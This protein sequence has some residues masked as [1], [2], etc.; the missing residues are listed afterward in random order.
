LSTLTGV[1]PSQVLCGYAAFA[2]TRER[3]L[4]EHLFA[5]LF[6]RDVL[7]FTER[8]LVTIAVI[9]SIGEA[10]PMLRSHLFIGLQ[11]GMSE[12][13]LHDFLGTIKSTISKK[14][15]KKAKAV[16]I[17]VLEKRKNL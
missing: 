4:K 1:P 3:F 16:V 15:F 5:D 9:V 14:K 13:Q 10:E 2:P 17:E 7:T 6:M 12:V 8:E 11:L